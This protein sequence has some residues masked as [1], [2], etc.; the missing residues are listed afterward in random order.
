MPKHGYAAFAPSDVADARRGFPSTI[1]AGTRRA[2]PGV[3]GPPVARRVLRR[4]AGLPGVPLQRRPRRAARRALRGGLPPVARGAGDRLAEHQRELYGSVVKT[5]GSWWKPDFSFNRTDIPW[6]GD[7][8]DP[9]TDHSQPE[10][11]ESHAVWIPTTTVAVNVPEAVLPFFLLRID[12]RTTTRRSTS[13]TASRCP[14]AGS[15]AP[16]ARCRGS[17]S[18]PLLDRHADDP[19]FR[20]LVLRGTLIVRRNGYLADL[21]ELAR[22]ACQIADAL[23]RR[24][25]GRPRPFTDALPAPHSHHPRSPR[26]GATATRSS[27][28]AWAYRGGRGRLPPRVPVARRARPRR[29]GH[30]RGARARRARPARLLR[31][32]QPA[33][34]RAR[35]RRG[36]APMDGPPTPPGG[37]RHRTSTSSTSNATAWPC[38]GACAPRA[39]TARS[40]RT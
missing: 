3:P 15:C 14:A 13:R 32:A 8:L 23:R 39:S 4:R 22:D 10:A 18:A 16:T 37:E 28:R 29:R 40:R 24:L 17:T 38:S 25:A 20:S 12:R 27:P 21:D 30:A 6:I 5:G 19:F 11:F 9:P 34:R 1:S 31:R 33:R 36:A 26:P 2:R 7:F 35:P